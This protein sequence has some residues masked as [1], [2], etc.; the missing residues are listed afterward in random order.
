MGVQGN[1]SEPKSWQLQSNCKKSTVADE[2][3]IVLSQDMRDTL[4]A[5]KMDA[6]DASADMKEE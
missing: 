2:E 4:L 3:D 5:C 1:A 6:D